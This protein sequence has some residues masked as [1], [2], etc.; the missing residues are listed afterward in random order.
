MN[1]LA[2]GAE[3]LGLALTANQLEQF[4]TYYREL[5]GWNERINLT[6]ITDYEEVQ[7]KHFLDSLTVMAAIRPADRA[8]SPKVI[9]VGTGAGLPGIPLKIVLPHIRLTLLEATGKKTRFL[10]HLVTQLG[11]KDVA[12]VTGRAEAIGHDAR[13]REAYDVALSRAPVIGHV[14]TAEPVFYQGLRGTPRCLVLLVQGSPRQWKRSETA[15]GKPWLE[16][17]CSRT[18]PWVVGLE[19]SVHPR[20]PRPSEHIRRPAACHV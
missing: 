13:H 15:E 17:L 8:R 7:S 10:N 1:I 5:V 11:L 20:L 14:F 3:E 16:P 19:Q 12:V 9:D 18:A 2:S 4:E 6:A